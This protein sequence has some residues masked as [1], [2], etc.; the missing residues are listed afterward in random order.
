MQEEFERMKREH[1]EFLE[2]RYSKW[3]SKEKANY[4]FGMI[5]FNERMQ[6]G[7]PLPYKVYAVSFLSKWFADNY[8]PPYDPDVLQTAELIAETYGIDRSIVKDL[9]QYYT[10][11][12]EWKEITRS[13]GLLEES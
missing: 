8:G 11:D 5:N 13:A 10:H 9:L 12:K 4:W 2:N 6:G 1:R 7:Y 3:S